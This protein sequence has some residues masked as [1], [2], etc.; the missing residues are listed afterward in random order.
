[1]RQFMAFF[2]KLVLGLFA[3]LVVVVAGLVVWDSIS[4]EEEPP[5]RTALQSLTDL[6]EFHAVSGYYE[7]VVLLEENPDSRLPDFLTGDR[8]VYIGKGSVDV[9]VDFSELDEDAITTSQDRTTATL[10]LPA[11]TL[12]KPVLDLEESEIFSHEQGVITKFQGSDLEREAQKKALRQITDAA[13]T[14]NRLVE[15]AETNTAAMLE[16]LLGGLGYT[17]VTVSWQE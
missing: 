3:V 17:D 1:M 10:R 13:S 2:V 6:N 7:T 4:E 16:D 8:L 9:V 12:G 11:P 14:E 15:Q 5:G